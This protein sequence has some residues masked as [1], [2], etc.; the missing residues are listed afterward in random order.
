V[1][2]GDWRVEPRKLLKPYS[3]GQKSVQEPARGG[4]PEVS[5]KRLL[6]RFR[7]VEK[8]EKAACKPGEGGCNLGEENEKYEEKCPG[9]ESVKGV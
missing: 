1:C 6:E 9:K 4:K 3:E 7:G 8:V 2:K 5:F